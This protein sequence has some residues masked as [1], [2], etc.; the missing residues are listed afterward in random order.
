MGITA[1][2]DALDRLLGR[3]DVHAPNVM[4]SGS[5]S[6]PRGCLLHVPDLVAGPL[7][8]VVNGGRLLRC[9]L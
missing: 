4:G 2:L 8:L 6:S 1:L 3:E 5:G 7:A 9:R